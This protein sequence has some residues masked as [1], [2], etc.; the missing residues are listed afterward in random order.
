MPQWRRDGKEIFFLAGNTL[1]AAPVQSDGTRFDSG[2]PAPLF[3]AQLGPSRRNHFTPSAD[4]Q[5]FLFAW[6]AGAERAGEVDVLLNWPPLP[7]A[8]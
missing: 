3:T 7:K 8:H 4:G 1:M 2:T 5:R 6:P